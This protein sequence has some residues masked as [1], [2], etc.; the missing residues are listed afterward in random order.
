MYYDYYSAKL[1]FA[2]LRIV[3]FLLH[4]IINDIA[5]RVYQYYPNR[6]EFFYVY[7]RALAARA[8]GQSHIVISQDANSQ[9][10]VYQQPRPIAPERKII[11]IANYLHRKR[12]RKK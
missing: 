6:T 2:F 11:P 1:K 7:R 8:Q 3:G 12:K 5:V 9:P 4:P 10:V